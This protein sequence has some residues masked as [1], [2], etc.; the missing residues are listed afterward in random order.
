MDSGFLASL[1]PGM[2]RSALRQWRIIARIDR[3]R[4]VFLLRPIPEL[5]DV[6]VGLDGLVP[7]LEPVFGALGA[8]LA[9]VEVADDVAEMVELERPAWRVGETDRSQRRH[10]LLFILGVGARLQRRFDHLAIDIEQPGVLA[11]YGVVIL[12][13]A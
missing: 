13:H 7:D 12:Q 5:T 3:V 11:R 4:E 2:T 6:L 9:D 8:D 10:E 1:G